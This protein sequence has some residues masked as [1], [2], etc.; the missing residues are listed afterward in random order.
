MPRGRDPAYLMA[1]AAKC[2]RLARNTLDEMAA[3]ELL[4]LAIELETEA[5]CD[6]M[7][8]DQSGGFTAQAF[9]PIEWPLPFERQ[10]IGR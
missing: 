10:K 8:P 9:Q 2:R 1:Q 4:A 6:T 5:N 7:S 3:R